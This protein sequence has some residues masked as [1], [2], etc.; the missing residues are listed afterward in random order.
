[1]L[2]RLLCWLFGHRAGFTSWEKVPRWWSPHVSGTRWY[3]ERRC[4]RCG[5]VLRSQRTHRDRRPIG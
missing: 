3:R 1:M 2:R 5:E 4:D